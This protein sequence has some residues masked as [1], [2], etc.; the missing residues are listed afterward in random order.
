M[1]LNESQVN[2]LL[3]SLIYLLY[4]KFI[5]CKNRWCIICRTV[6]VMVTSPLPFFNG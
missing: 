4:D 3:E 2:F 6:I 5:L 1:D